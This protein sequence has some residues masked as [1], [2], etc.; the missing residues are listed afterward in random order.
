MGSRFS[1]RKA[2]IV[3]LVPATIIVCFETASA[4]PSLECSIASGSQ[5]ET[6]TCLEAMTK[7]A[8]A[9]MEAA[10]VFARNSAK[11]LDEA[12]GRTVVIPALEAGQ[13]AWSQYRD[14]HCEY[15]GST[16]GGGSGTGIAIQSCRIELTR[17]RTTE[18]MQFAR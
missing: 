13:T 11:A 17:Q 16:F 9:A 1:M 4:D 3:A 15:V 10:L 18:L 12:T 14:K 7:S 2:F 5:V 6:G 8:D